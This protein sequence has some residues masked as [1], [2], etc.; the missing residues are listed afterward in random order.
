MDDNSVVLVYIAQHVVARD[1]V[2]TVGHDIVLRDGFFRQLQYLLGVNLLLRGLFFGLFFG[3]VFAV[4]V[5]E[6][7][8]Q[9]LLP[10]GALFFFEGILVRIAQYEFFA[11]YGYKQFVAG[12]EVMQLRQLVQRGIVH[13]DVFVL[14]EFA[15]YVFAF[16]LVGFRFFAQDGGNLGAGAGGS[17]IHF[18]FRLHALRLGG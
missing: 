16:L 7:E 5:A 10:V 15:H 18:P 9:E 6:G 3:S 8:S 2:A 11:A 4:F 12:M 1:G 13:A 17:G 14:E